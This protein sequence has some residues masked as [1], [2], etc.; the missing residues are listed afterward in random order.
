[1]SQYSHLYND[2]KW[3]RHR[4]V[5]LAAHPLCVMCAAAG[6]VEEAKVADHIEPHKGDLELFWDL[7]NLQSLCLVHHSVTKQREDRR[8]CAQGCGPDGRPLDRGH[9]WNGGSGQVASQ[10]RGSWLGPMSHPTWFRRVLVPM[11]IVCGAPASGKSTYVAKQMQGSSHMLIDVDGIGRK[12]FGRPARALS[13]PELL[14]CLRARND[15]LGSFMSGDYDKSVKHLWLIV[16]EPRAEARQW[17]AEHVRPKSIVVVE[18]PLGECLARALKDE[19]TVKRRGA[20]ARE[21]IE[22]WWRAYTKREGDKI[23]I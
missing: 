23:I 15:M 17:W 12:K 5:H 3:R 19:D 13:R 10:D 21:A 18:T 9:P 11:T 1:M 2:R 14:D 4:A 6:R 22:Q 16:A 20:G 8:G 7:G